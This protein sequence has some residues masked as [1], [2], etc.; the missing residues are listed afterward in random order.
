MPIRV[1]DH[2]ENI[3]I[4]TDK[5]PVPNLHALGYLPSGLYLLAETV[6]RLEI[7]TSQQ[8]P[9]KF[10]QQS[11]QQPLQLSLD[12]TGSRG[13]VVTNYFGW[14]SISLCSYLRLVRL[15]ALM[16]E[17]G[18]GTSDIRQPSNRKH[19]KNTCTDYVK[20]VVP[21]VY[22]WRNKVAAHPAI[23]DPFENDP[24]GTLELSI[25]V[26]VVYAS[27]YF[28]AGVIQWSR[29]DETSA[30]EEWA[31]TDVFEQLSPRLWPERQLTPIPGFTRGKK[32]MTCLVVVLSHP[33]EGEIVKRYTGATGEEFGNSFIIYRENEIIIGPDKQPNIFPFERFPIEWVKSWHMEEGS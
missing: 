9:P 14:F 31:L 3:T 28:R 21:A 23:T 25:M 32:K 8:Q 15:L 27:P 29:E 10:I 17:Q 33:E 22:Q 5:F 1:L 20:R 19:I 26:P 16:E 18:W 12:M 6:R 24:L 30:L 11:F 4:D 13:A 2:L 7:E